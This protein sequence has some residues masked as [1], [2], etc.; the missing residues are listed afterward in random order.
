MLDLKCI[1]KSIFMNKKKTSHIYFH[2]CF[3]VW[4]SIHYSIQQ[5]QNFLLIIFINSSLIPGKNPSGVSFAKF[6]YFIEKLSS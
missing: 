2:E 3:C 6:E 4:L 1:Q 5:V